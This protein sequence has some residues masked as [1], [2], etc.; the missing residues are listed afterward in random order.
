MFFEYVGTVALNS[1]RASL[2]LLVF[3]FT[4]QVTILF[5]LSALPQFHSQ[6]L[7]FSYGILS[8]AY[9]KPTHPFCKPGVGN[10]L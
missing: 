10:L 2:T 4:F 8:H 9:F 6:S 5:Y 3:N 7:H 1:V